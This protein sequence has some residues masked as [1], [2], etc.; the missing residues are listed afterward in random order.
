MK[1]KILSSNVRRLNDGEKKKLIKLVVRTQK[2]NLLCFLQTK[3]Q[4]M[5]L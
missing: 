3:M 4:E 5:L 2:A 1:I